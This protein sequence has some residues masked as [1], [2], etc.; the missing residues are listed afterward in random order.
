MASYL[1]GPAVCLAALSSMDKI[2]VLWAT[3]SALTSCCPAVNLT[4]K[5]QDNQAGIRRP[6]RPQQGLEKFNPRKKVCHVSFLGC[7]FKNL[8]LMYTSVV[9]WLEYLAMNLWAGVC[10]LDSLRTAHLTLIFPS[11]WLINGY[12]G[13]LGEGKTVVNQKSNWPCVRLLGSLPPQTPRAN[14]RSWVPASRVAIVGA[15]NWPCNVY[16]T[17]ISTPLQHAIHSS[18]VSYK[19][20]N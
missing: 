12:M 13:K 6:T 8:F 2:R 20:V 17:C 4:G 15:P 10:I 1:A 14:G 16:A 11:G 9:Q 7:L 3:G 19:T 18:W 5:L